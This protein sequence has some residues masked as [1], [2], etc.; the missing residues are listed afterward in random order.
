ME[1]RDLRRLPAAPVPCGYRLRRYRA[2]DARAWVAIHRGAERYHRITAKLFGSQ[3]PGS[4][5]LRRRRMV[6]VVDAAGK[7]VGTCTAWFGKPGPKGDVG[8]LHWLAVRTAHQGKGLGWVLTVAVLRII[9]RL[10]HRR[11]YLETNT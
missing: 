6:F 11:A 10:G 2:G 9:K 8:Q 7:A 4:E 1:R 3:F 5:A